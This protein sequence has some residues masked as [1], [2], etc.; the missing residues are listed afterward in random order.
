M[1]AVWY[2]P[3]Q[4]L[5]VQE[6]QWKSDKQLDLEDE[7]LQHIVLNSSSD[8]IGLDES[9]NCSPN[10]A[11]EHLNNEPEMPRQSSTSVAYGKGKSERLVT[12]SQSAL[13]LGAASPLIQ[14]ARANGN[15]NSMP[16][17][18]NSQSPLLLEAT[19]PCSSR[20]A[21]SPSSSDMLH[22]QE[23]FV[24]DFLKQHKEFTNGLLT[25]NEIL[26]EFE[27]INFNT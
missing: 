4:L 6:A 22:F 14:L 24:S 7:T 5:E 11:I 2:C 19:P 13:L 26:N 10:N 12:I 8:D 9:A 25:H 18:S 21:S 16:F 23:A 3:V 20:G 27:S 1:S 17:M 15:G